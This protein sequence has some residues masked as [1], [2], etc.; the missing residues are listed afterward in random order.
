MRRTRR[1]ERVAVPV[2]AVVLLAGCAQQ[3]GGTAVS[4][5]DNP[6]SVAGL[7]V[8]SGYSGPRVGVPDADVVVENTDDGPVDRLAGNAIGD[9]EDY[10]HEEFRTIAKGSFEPVSTIMSWD[11]SE[12]RGPRFCGEPTFD[13]VN[14]A[15][16]SLGDVIGWDRSYLMPQLVDDFGPMA[17]VM[18]LAHEYGHAIQYSA[19]LIADDD[20]GI[21]F[22]QQADC[23]AGAFMRHVAEGR[24]THFE[25]DTSDGLNNVLA[26]MVLF[27]DTAPNDPDSIHGSAFERVTAVQIG[28]TDGAGACARIDAAEVESRRADLP[29]YFDGSDDGELAVT[30]ESVDLIFRSFDRVFELTDPP[31]LDLSG[32]DLGCSDAAATSPVSYCPATNTVGVDL[33]ELAER[34][35]P[36]TLVSDEFDTDV[37]GDYNAYVLVASRYALAVQH[38]NGQS[39][40]DPRTA[41]RAACLSGVI[42]AALSPMSALAAELE[43]GADMVWLSPGDLDEAVSGLLTDGLAAS[44]VNGTTVPS[45]FSRVDAFRTGVLGGEG[46]C[47]G[48]YR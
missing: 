18:V 11:P 45:G 31:E 22:E 8:T 3:V 24:A 19:G 46:A 1:F 20:P 42:S 9:I 30:A 26:S 17:A 16:C 14:A 4:I 48:R 21:V 6:F 37:R 25:L 5:Y 23:F 2:M 12:R 10:W 33:E 28:F 34:G 7:P 13:F 40:T 29:Q 44:D 41:L 35:T 47:N 27:R 39:L 15:Y 43:P 32:A 38:A 36:T